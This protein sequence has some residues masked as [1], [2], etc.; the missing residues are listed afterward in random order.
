MRRPRILRLCFAA[1]AKRR[2]FFGLLDSGFSAADCPR[3]EKEPCLI[4]EDGRPIPQHRHT[5]ERAIDPRAA[6]NPQ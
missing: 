5:P 3:D 2:S 6:Y 4:M 1:M